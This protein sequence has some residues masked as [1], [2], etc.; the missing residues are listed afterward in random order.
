L[1][2]VAWLLV[3]RDRLAFMAA[4][5][6]IA[7][8]LFAGRTASLAP[9]IRYTVPLAPP[10]AVAAGALSADLFRR[11]RARAGGMIVTI[12][13]AGATACWA[14][15]Y[16]NVFRQPDARLTASQWLLANVPAES[17]ILVEPSH[18]IPP[19]GS[20]LTAVNFRS[21]Y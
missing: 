13:V 15:A 1:A 21:E 8:A 3:R 19:M 9:F 12:F 4:A 5:F 20:Y 17:K 6:P 7:Y 11:P 2:G 14:I 10:L 16:M 18:N